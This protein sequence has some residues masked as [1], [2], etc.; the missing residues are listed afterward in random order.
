[1]QKVLL[2]IPSVFIIAL[3]A[4]AIVF[5]S[6]PV[7]GPQSYQQDN[8]SQTPMPTSTISPNSTPTPSPLLTTTPMP[9]ASSLATI[10]QL[11]ASFGPLGGFRILTPTNT[12]YDTSNLNLT[13]SGQ[14]IAAGLSMSYSI[15]GQERFS[16]PAKVRQVHDW[17]PFF[18]G[19]HESVTLPPLATG[20]HSITVYGQLLVHDCKEA[21]TTV[22]FT[23]A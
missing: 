18:G 11:S 3:I 9:K 16:I 8:L 2:I 7:D 4:I 19:I 20:S 10:Q 17:D 13:V 15:D 1:M 12:S 14:A 21:Q 22:Y 23:I 6:K 5:A